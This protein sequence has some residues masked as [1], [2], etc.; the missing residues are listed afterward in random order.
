MEPERLRWSYTD[1][2]VYFLTACTYARQATLANVGIHQAFRRFAKTARDHDVLVGRYVI[3]PDH[4]HLFAAFAPLS[5]PLS[6]W[7][8]GLKRALAEELKRTA[9]RAPFWQRGF[10]DHILRSEESY[11]QKWRYVRDNPVRA[12][13]VAMAEDWPW[14]GEIVPLLLRNL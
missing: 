11:K 12:G 9:L 5:P 2:P 4:L 1:C 3:M 14:Q 13:L 8:K 6:E 10:F 7:F